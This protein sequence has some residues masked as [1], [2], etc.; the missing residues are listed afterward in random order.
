LQIEAP[1]FDQGEI[2]DKGHLN[3]MKVLRQ[4]SAVVV[5]AYADV[6]EDNVI[7]L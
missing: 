6:P 7:C 5:A 1:S 3:R 4:R 2:T